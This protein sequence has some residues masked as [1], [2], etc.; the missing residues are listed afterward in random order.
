MFRSWYES[1]TWQNL[2]GRYWIRYKSE[3]VKMFLDK[4]NNF[5]MPIFLHAENV[6]FLQLIFE[7][8]KKLT[9]LWWSI[10]KHVIHWNKVNRPTIA[11]NSKYPQEKPPSVLNSK[12]FLKHE[13]T[14]SLLESTKNDNRFPGETLHTTLEKAK[15]AIPA[16]DK[17]S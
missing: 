14:R 10:F 2:T 8:K 16:R 13:V 15:I 1:R 7:W 12:R 5:Q 17:T 9:I 6:W 3:K 11:C 4:I